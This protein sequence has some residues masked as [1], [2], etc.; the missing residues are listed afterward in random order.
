MEV[1]THSGLTNL[2]I[3]SYQ[4]LANGLVNVE[5]ESF[6]MTYESDSLTLYYN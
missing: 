6:I 4:L 1:V 2:T 3:Y 5:P